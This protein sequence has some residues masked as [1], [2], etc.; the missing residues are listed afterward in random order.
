M[1]ITGLSN[2]LRDRTQ[3]DHNRKNRSGVGFIQL[4]RRNARSVSGVWAISG[5]ISN[6]GS[7]RCP[8]G[9]GGLSPK[10]GLFS[11]CPM[12]RCQWRLVTRRRISLGRICA[13][14]GN[15]SSRRKAQSNYS[16]RLMARFLESKSLQKLG[17]QPMPFGPSAISSVC[18]RS[19][20]VFCKTSSALAPAALRWLVCE[21]PPMP[22]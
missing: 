14:P 22:L 18:F 9:S 21:G 10:G 19:S 17:A 3:G 13:D 7:R 6:S 5:S 15:M 2:Q 16:S 8:S 20:E 1:P 12:S 11:A 4:S